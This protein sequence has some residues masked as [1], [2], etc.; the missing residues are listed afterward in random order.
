MPEHWVTMRVK[1]SIGRKLEELGMAIREA[2]DVFNALDE[3]ARQHRFFCAENIDDNRRGNVLISHGAKDRA[4]NIMPRGHMS[5]CQ[6]ISSDYG[7]TLIQVSKVCRDGGTG[8]LHDISVTWDRS[9]NSC[10]TKIGDKEYSME[11]RAQLI[12]EDLFFPPNS[13]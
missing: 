8:G 2:V 13:P 10:Q 3:D 4:G 12:L 9:T 7:R 1:C 6:A 11:K 5:A